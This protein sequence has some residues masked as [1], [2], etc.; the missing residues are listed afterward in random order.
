MRI[1]YF[2]K[3]VI[4]CL[5]AALLAGCSLSTPFYIFRNGGNNAGEDENW[6]DSLDFNRLTASAGTNESALHHA[7]FGTSTLYFY[8]NIDHHAVIV[9]CESEDDTPFDLE[10]VIEEYP[11]VEI[12]PH[13]FY[14]A[15]IRSY[16]QTKGRI[17]IDES[18]FYGC[19]Q[20]EK[21]QFSDCQVSVSTYAFADSAL[22]QAT[23]QNCIAYLGESSFADCHG[24]T[25]FSITGGDTCILG[26]AFSGCQQI[27]T[28]HISDSMLIAEEYAFN[29]DSIYRLDIS[30]CELDLRQQCFNECG[31]ALVNIYRCTGCIPA[32]A[33]VGCTNPVSISIKGETPIKE[34]A[35]AYTE[36]HIQIEF[37]ANVPSI[38][39]TAFKE[40]KNLFLVIPD[41]PCPA[42]TFAELHNLR[43]L[44]AQD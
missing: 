28:L 1:R 37:D 12:K 9:R 43:W 13:V 41:T 26:Y 31:A 2:C 27:D 14:D 36:R 21:V 24:M 42:R 3:I 15:P 10:G 5:C 40:C 44:P 35:F 29:A 18:A 32:Y 17:L 25:D 20:L 23:F 22:K 38:D 6:D 4:L 19:K 7:Q 11:I 30:K 33:F 39:P 16:T 34:F 8:L